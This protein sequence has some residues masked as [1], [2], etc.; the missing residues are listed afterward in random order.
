ML[1]DR[2][3]AVFLVQV[4]ARADMQPPQRGNLRL[5]DSESGDI[6]EVPG[7]TVD[8]CSVS[9]KVQVGNTYILANKADL[10][11]YWNS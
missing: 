11:K 8:G 4:L 1:A 10:E 6:D 3:S 9:A 7:Q 5:L 2:A